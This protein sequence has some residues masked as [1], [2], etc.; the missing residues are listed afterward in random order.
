ML[1]RIR[2]QVT[3]LGEKWGQPFSVYLIEIALNV[4]PRPSAGRVS[5]SLHTN[6]LTLAIARTNQTISE[7]TINKMGEKLSFADHLFP[8]SP[9]MSG[10]AFL[11]RFKK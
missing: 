10:S 4:F 2:A 7:N 3:R 8:P 11:L 6:K 5:G 1:C 9:C